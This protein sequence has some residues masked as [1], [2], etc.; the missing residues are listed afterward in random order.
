MRLRERQW[1]LAA[2]L[3]IL[4]HCLRVKTSRRH[5]RRRVEIG[6]GKNCRGVPTRVRD[7]PSPLRSRE[8]TGFHKKKKKTTFFT[9]VHAFAMKISHSPTEIYR[10]TY[11]VNRRSSDNKIQR[12]QF[13]DKS[14]KKK[15]SW[16]I[17]V[18][19]LRI[20]NKFFND[21]W[22]EWRTKVWI[23]FAGFLDFWIKRAKFHFFLETARNFSPSFLFFFFFLKKSVTRIDVLRKADLISPG[24]NRRFFTK[25]DVPRKIK[26]LGAES[27]LTSRFAQWTE[28][29][30]H[31]VASSINERNEKLISCNFARSIN[32]FLIDSLQFIVF[33]IDCCFEGL[34]RISKV[35]AYQV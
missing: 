17:L 19:L 24:W 7:T 34:S 25:F 20:P 28:Q 14:K 27:F 29:W 11:S 8:K 9:K 4:L 13:F 22:F 5:R 21:L 35:N 15:K 1:N 18:L 2:P 16:R 3:Y 23:N 6:Q 33:T 30:R 26:E 32:F 12:M 10:A 31:E